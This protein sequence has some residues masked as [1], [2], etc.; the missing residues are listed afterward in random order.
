[1]SI[2]AAPT[3]SLGPVIRLVTRTPSQS[4]QDFRTLIDVLGRPGTIKSLDVPEELAEYSVPPAVLVAGGLA[5]VDIT[6]AVLSDRPAD[7][8]AVALYAATGASEAPPATAQLVV[9]LRPPTPAEILGLAR[10]DALHP[11]FGCRLILAV[12]T[13]EESASALRVRL[14]GPGVDGQSELRITG[15]PAGVF[16]A[17]AAANNEFPAGI[18][19]FLVSADGKVAGLPRSSRI[20]IDTQGDS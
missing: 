19:T 2:S 16:E 14:Q 15:V 12:T 3:G 20:R 18:D 5:D 7:P 9:A 6:L 13:F 8:C 1:V 11:E 17:L 4:Q 10:G